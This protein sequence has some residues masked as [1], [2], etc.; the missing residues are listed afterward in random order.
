M[1]VALTLGTIAM[2]IASGLRLAWLIREEG[3]Q[4][5]SASVERRLLASDG[6]LVGIGAG[7]KLV[8][9]GPSGFG[10]LPQGDRLVVFVVH[11]R[12]AEHDVAY[13]S[14]VARALRDPASP[15]QSKYRLWGICDSGSGCEGLERAAGFPILGYLDP[16]QMRGVALADARREALVFRGATR[17]GVP[18]AMGDRP[19]SEARAIEAAVQ[20]KVN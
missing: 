16:F 2:L 3:A 6:S 7:G 5:Q 12:A 19:G 9:P 17:A 14:G 1:K 8:T 4:R 15:E 18:V 11:R 20:D 13:W 10:K